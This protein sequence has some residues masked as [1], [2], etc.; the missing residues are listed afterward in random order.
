MGPVQSVAIVGREFRIFQTSLMLFSSAESSR[1][2]SF[3][4]H[5]GR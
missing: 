3:I 4:V 2:S 1:T 5:S